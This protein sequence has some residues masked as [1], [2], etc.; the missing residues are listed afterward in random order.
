LLSA[1]AG[2]LVILENP[3]AHLHPRAQVRIADLCA[4]ATVSG[5][6]VLLET[7]SDHILN[8]VRVSVHQHRLPAEKV[9]VHFFSRPQ[10]EGSPVWRELHMKAGGRLTER[11]DGFFDEIERQLSEL[12]QDPVEDNV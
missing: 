1:K 3:E 4:R 11:P 5:V 2:D 10:P 7:H 6:Q 12:L 8:G 9:A